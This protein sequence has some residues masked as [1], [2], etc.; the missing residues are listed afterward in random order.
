MPWLHSGVDFML[1]DDDPFVPYDQLKA[2]NERHDRELPYEKTLGRVKAS[3]NIAAIMGRGELTDRK[4]DKYIKAGF[5]SAEFREARRAL[6]AKKAK[7]QGNFIQT[8]SGKLIY[9]PQ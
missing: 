1:N 4:I 2:A 9:S 7:R 6:M 3:W 8:E 5:Y